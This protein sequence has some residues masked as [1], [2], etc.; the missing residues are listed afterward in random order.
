MHVRN[1]LAKLGSTSRS[2]A[3]AKARAL[4]ALTP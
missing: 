1:I 4:G 2:Q 3:V